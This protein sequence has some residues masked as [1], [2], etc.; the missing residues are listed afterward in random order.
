MTEAIGI[1]EDLL[2]Q[3]LV[4]GGTGLMLAS[5]LK[6][7][8]KS[9]SGNKE[10]YGED[11]LIIEESVMEA[12]AEAI[13]LD[14][15]DPENRTGYAGNYKAEFKVNWN[16]GLTATFTILATITEPTRADQLHSLLSLVLRGKDESLMLTPYHAPLLVRDG[17]EEVQLTHL[18]GL[19]PE[20][21]EDFIDVIDDRPETE[22]GKGFSDWET[23]TPRFN[24]IVTGGNERYSGLVFHRKPNATLRADGKD[25]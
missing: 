24:V 21:L 16:G 11:N 23:E 6:P 19:P 14:L 9:A 15:R 13:G 8:I 1:I 25:S 5:G 2:E 4:R 17:G 20:V 18:G 12:Y 3:T 7:V 10:V 22:Y